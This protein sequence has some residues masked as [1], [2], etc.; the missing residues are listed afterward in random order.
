[1][2]KR[3]DKQPE[4]PDDPPARDRPKRPETEPAEAPGGRDAARKE[5]DAR[6][7]STR[8]GER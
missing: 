1:M 8:K 6:N 4:L 2:T 7:K 5:Q 3:N